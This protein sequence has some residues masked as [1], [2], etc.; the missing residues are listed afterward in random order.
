MLAGLALV[1]AVIGFVLFN[2]IKQE[3]QVGH[4][5]AGV[6]ALAAGEL[7]RAVS[8][9][10]A[11]DG[12]LDSSALI[13]SAHARMEERDRLYKQAS[14]YA[15][16]GKWWQAARS[17][18][19]MQELQKSYQDSEAL[20]ARARKVN[21]A[22]FYTHYPPTGYDSEGRRIN[23]YDGPDRAGVYMMQ[24]DG[25]DGKQVGDIERS[26]QTYAIA[27]DG[28]SMVYSIPSGP[29]R[30]YNFERQSITHLSLP[31][32]DPAN[33]IQR[34]IFTQDGKSL[35]LMTANTAFTYDLSRTPAE[36]GATLEPAQQE[37]REEY[38]NR[39]M[40]V[41]VLVPTP[42]ALTNMVVRDGASGEQTTISTE[43]GRVDGALFSKDQRYL[44]YR[45]CTLTNGN[46]TFECVIKLA[47]L[48]H[49]E[50][51]EEVVARIPDLPLSNFEDALLAEFTQDGKHII[52]F[53][54]YVR[55]RLKETILYNIE[56]EEAN[57]LDPLSF[58]VTTGR[59]RDDVLV[60]G[61]D[62]LLDDYVPGLQEWKGRNSLA[63]TGQSLQRH[64]DHFTKVKSHWISVTPNNRYVLVLKS[65]I[66]ESS[67]FYTMSVADLTWN[68]AEPYH[69][70]RTI[71][72]TKSL[73]RDW[74]PEMK[75]LADGYTL[76]MSDAN[77]SGY[78]PDIHAYSLDA[79][80]EAEVT[81]V[82][83]A[84]LLEM[85]SFPEEKK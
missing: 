46:E 30:L 31:G 38:E 63:R 62:Y 54:D 39:S 79:N 16:V 70:G 47:D 22:I 69:E 24:A 56:T 64:T 12:Y 58:A 44:I 68:S 48:D 85:Y 21:G 7:D 52:F 67:R 41:L 17:I 40:K 10:Q 34:A 76:I 77:D 61:T 4:Y 35:V 73:P 18:L 1:V 9:L 6:D 55:T 26:S 36:D 25:A 8:E 13:D 14:N 32:S 23:V 71:F 83:A 45:V 43:R 65:H 20:L 50:R 81:L 60:V 74:L 42:Q 49:P 27:S 2:Y 75:I 33:A 57:K 82:E 3:V 51:Q 11:S 78:V 5:H 80:D 66:T 53:L 37:T 59:G 29:P 28:L 15:G 84:Q 72:S 19:E